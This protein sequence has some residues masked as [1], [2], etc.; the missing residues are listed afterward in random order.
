MRGRR[1]LLPIGWAAL[2]IALTSVPGSAVPD[3]G[4][5]STDKLVHLILYGVLGAL[6]LHA[7]WNPPRPLRSLAIAVVAT[8]AF[9]VVDEVHQKLVPGRS[10]DMMDWVADS[11]GGATGA[12]AAIALRRRGETPA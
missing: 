9:G 1:W 2:I 8:S 6:V 11:I 4:G 3:V 10:A 5:E 12:L 7:A